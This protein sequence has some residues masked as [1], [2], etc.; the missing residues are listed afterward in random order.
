MEKQ[1]RNKPNYSMFIP[2]KIRGEIDELIN[3]GEFSS[4]SAFLIAAAKFY[5]SYHFKD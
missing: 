2:D 3:E 4:V 1:K 5:I